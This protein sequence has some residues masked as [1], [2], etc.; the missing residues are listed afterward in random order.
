MG[1]NY[2]MV[3]LPVLKD[4]QRSD[5]AGEV[6]I[7]SCGDVDKRS[8]FSQYW[9]LLQPF[10]LVMDVSTDPQYRGLVFYVVS[11]ELLLDGR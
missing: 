9:E 6:I 7:H 3:H 5:A 4:V 8:M 11:S 2:G 10:S 1:Q